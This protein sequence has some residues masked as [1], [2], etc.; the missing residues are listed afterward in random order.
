MALKYQRS[1]P[2][3]RTLSSTLNP[4]PSALNILDSTQIQCQHLN[5]APQTSEEVTQRPAQCWRT[6]PPL[7]EAPW[8]T[9]TGF[10]FRVGGVYPDPP[11]FFLLGAI[12]ITPY[13]KTI[14]KPKGNYIGALG[15]DLGLR[16]SSCKGYRSLLKFL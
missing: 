16:G 7:R 9:T 15:H 10:G 4:N 5:T 6:R 11:M 1:N 2:Q 13:P 14:T 8:A 12:F 3:R